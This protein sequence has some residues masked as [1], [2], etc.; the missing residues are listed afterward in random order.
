MKMWLCTCLARQI[1]DVDHKSL[2]IVAFLIMKMLACMQGTVDM[3]TSCGAP[4]FASNVGLHS[5]AAEFGYL[6]TGL[7]K[8]G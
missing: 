8:I 4:A 6:V 7:V 5:R 2:S 1:H 3:L